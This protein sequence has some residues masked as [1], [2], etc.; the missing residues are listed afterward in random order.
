MDCEIVLYAYFPCM[1]PQ[2]ALTCI[3]TGGLRKKFHGWREIRERERSLRIVAAVS[4]SRS[5]T[6][7]TGFRA[8]A[9]N[10]GIKQARVK[11]FDWRRFRVSV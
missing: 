6:E 2:S 4:R 11:V 7:R 10:G 1:P 8:G 5:N 9:G 3:Y